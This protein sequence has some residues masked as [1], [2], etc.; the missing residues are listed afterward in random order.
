M[1]NNFFK[2]VAKL[3]NNYQKLFDEK[4]VTKKAICY[5]CTPFRDK[6]HLTDMQTLRIARDE[7]DVSELVSISEA[8]EVDLQNIE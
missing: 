4:K 6:Y 8:F 1:S 5:I 3:Q 7:A 2:E